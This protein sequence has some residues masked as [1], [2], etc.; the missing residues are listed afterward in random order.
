MRLEVAML[1][2]SNPRR[3]HVGLID[4]AW[5]IDQA[6]APALARKCVHPTAFWP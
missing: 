2:V 3:S 5:E 4:T 6:Q 1:P